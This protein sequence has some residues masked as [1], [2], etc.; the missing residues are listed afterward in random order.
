MTSPVSI[1]WLAIGESCQNFFSCRL[2]NVYCSVNHHYSFEK[3][4]LLSETDGK[5]RKISLN[6]AETS[7]NKRDTPTSLGEISQ[8]SRRATS[9]LSQLSTAHRAGSIGCVC[10]HIIYVDGSTC[11]PV[12]HCGPNEWDAIQGVPAKARSSTTNQRWS[13]YKIQDDLVYGLWMITHKSYLASRRSRS[14]R[15]MPIVEA[16]NVYLECA[17]I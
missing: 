2:N 3:A 15:Q 17:T 1:L 10:A 13:Q 4:F 5:Q 14:K 8:T 16:R 7:E 12:K 6:C 11:Y 9:T